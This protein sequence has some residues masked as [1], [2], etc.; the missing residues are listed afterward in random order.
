MWAVKV[1]SLALGIVALSS[2]GLALSVLPVRRFLR[3]REPADPPRWPRVSVLKPVKG[4]DPAAE[5]G[6]ESFI[7]QDYPGELEVVFAVEGE[8]DPVLPLIRTLQAA[9]PDRPGREVRLVHSSARPDVM[10]KANNVMA[11][12]AAATGE[13]YVSAD[14]DVIAGPDDVKR[15]VRQLLSNEGRGGRRIGAVG[16]IPVYRGMRDLGAGLIGAYYSPFMVIFYSLKDWLGPRDV[17]P[18]TYYAVLPEALAAAGGWGRI[19]DNI[20]DDSTM[21][22]YLFEAGFES[23]MS[24]VTASVPEPTKRVR[25]YWGHQHRWHLTYRTT[26]PFALY[27]LSPLAHP[28]GLALALP[29]LLP[30]GPGLAALGLYCL[31]RWVVIAWLNLVV[32]REPAMWRWLWLMPVS[33][34]VLTGAWARALVDTRTTWRGIPYRVAQGGKLVRLEPGA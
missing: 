5:E 19:A 32:L 15:L 9:H 33:E 23:V 14:S 13:V 16:A 11:A 31:T 24:H 2:L 17:F 1:A 3:R 10:G 29:F 18:G 21:G 27:L 8:D 30:G 34:L 7:N 22:R 25:E 6:F 4:L 28:A 26:L 12:Q 20:A